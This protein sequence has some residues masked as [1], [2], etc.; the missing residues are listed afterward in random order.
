MAREDLLKTSLSLQILYIPP[1][2]GS[3][4]FKHSAKVTNSNFI[5]DDNIKEAYGIGLKLL[6]PT[7]SELE[8][9]LELHKNSIVFDAY[10]FIPT[11]IYGW[12]C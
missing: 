5:M 8:H 6:N 12:T 9:G 1:V 11:A 10:S 3:S 7:K 2:S 4:L